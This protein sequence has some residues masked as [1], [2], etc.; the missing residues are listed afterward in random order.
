MVSAPNLGSTERKACPELSKNSK[1]PRGEMH[2]SLHSYTRG[3]IAV[4]EDEEEEEA[5]KTKKV[6]GAK[7][8]KM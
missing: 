1:T 8:W 2:F 3:Y 7:Y 4:E 6:L 5:K